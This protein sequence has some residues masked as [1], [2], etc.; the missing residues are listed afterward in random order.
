MKNLNRF[1]IV[2]RSDSDV[3]ELEDSPTGKYVKVSDVEE[4]DRWIPCN[5][6]L[7]EQIGCYLIYIKSAF[8]MAWGFFNSDENWAIQNTFVSPTHWK[9]IPEPPEE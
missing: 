8:E 2:M 5:E 1:N 7:P 4:A 6:R 3:Y 9:P